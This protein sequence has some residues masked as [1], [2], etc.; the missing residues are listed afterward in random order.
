M[1]HRAMSV[2]DQFSVVAFPWGKEIITVERLADV[3]R[4]AEGLNFHSV[5]L[6]M[7]NVSLPDDDRLVGIHTDN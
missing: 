1:E 5:N 4:H 2:M 7:V 3:A 6:P